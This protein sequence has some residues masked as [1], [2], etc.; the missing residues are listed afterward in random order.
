MPPGLGGEHYL[1]VGGK[2]SSISLAQI[3]AVGKRHGISNKRIDDIIEM[4]TEAIGRFKRFARDYGLS[5]QTLA[6]IKNNLDVQQASLR[7]SGRTQA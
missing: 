2:G 7:R 3:G 4:T 1:A 6:T 5:A